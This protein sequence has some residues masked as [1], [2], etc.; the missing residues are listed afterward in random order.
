MIGRATRRAR[1]VAV[2]RIGPLVAARQPV[3]TD[4][5]PATWGLEI[6]SNGS[7]WSGGVDGVGGLDL[8]AVAAEYGTPLHV[9]RADR[10][11]ANAAPAVSSRDVFYSYKTNPVPTV[12]ARLHAHGAGAEVISPYE[13]WLA[14]RLGVPGGRLIYNGPAKSPDSIR[15][16]IRHGALLVNANSASE[17]ALAASI[18]ADERRV[19]SLGLRVTVPGSWGGQ[20]GIAS[21]DAAASAVLAALDDRWVDLRGLHVHRGITIRDAITMEGYV[22]AVLDRAAELRR[23]T[24]WAPAILDLGGSLACPTVAAVPW[25]QFRLNRALGSDLLPPNPST[26]L[27]IADAAMIAAELVAADAAAAGIA[28]PR[29]VLEPGRALTGD[30]Q[31]LLTSVVDVNNGPLPHAVLDAGTNI[32]EPVTSEFH[33]LFSVT[34]PGVPSTTGYR[35]V[36]PICTP[37]DVLVNHWRLPP[38]A[39]G[40]VLAFMDTGAYFV[41]FSTTFSFPKPAIVVQDGTDVRVARRAETFDDIISLDHPSV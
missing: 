1:A 18:A 25:R 38:L 14:I 20:F 37:A 40:H 26:C 7:L 11:D 6:G 3:R 28:A 5:P 39:S 10:L 16:A 21:I 32:A 33:Q 35:L 8:A 27:S 23:R 22:R 29:I 9:V 4:I 19:I 34:A 12:L 31:F 13:L 17:A 36:G 15:A 41:P 24:G 2:A 30:T